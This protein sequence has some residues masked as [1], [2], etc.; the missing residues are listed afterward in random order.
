M[1][2]LRRFTDHNCNQNSSKPSD[3]YFGERSHSLALLE[4]GELYG[5][6]RNDDG[7]LGNGTTKDSFYPRLIDTAPGRV[8]KIAG[9][10]ITRLPFLENG[11]VYAWGRNDIGQLGDGTTKDHT[12]PLLIKTIQERVISIAAGYCHS[13]ALLENGEVYAW[14]RNDDGQL[15]NGENQDSKYPTPVNAISEKVVRIAAGY[16]QSLALLEN[17]KVYGWGWNGRGQRGL[18][19]Y[20]E[21]FY[22]NI[23]QL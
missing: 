23:F 8:I 13:L 21:Y 15:G 18:V 19:N 2:R 1:N 22:Q 7:Q 10:A 11:E 9:G 14:G 5:W 17:G 4:T 12:R 6:G 16:Q 20:R 3:K